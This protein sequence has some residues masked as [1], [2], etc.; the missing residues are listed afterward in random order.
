MR[1]NYAGGARVY[2][3]MVL[4]RDTGIVQEETTRRAGMLCDLER[5]EGERD[6]TLRIKFDGIKVRGALMLL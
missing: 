3:A 5:S 2:E 4:H 1:C 6:G